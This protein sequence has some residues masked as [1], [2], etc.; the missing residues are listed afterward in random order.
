MAIR[1]PRWRRIVADTF[2][3]PLGV[4]YAS[5]LLAAIFAPEPV[6]ADFAT[7]GGGLL[8]MRP[9]AFY[10][11]SSDLVMLESDLPALIRRYPELRLPVTI[12][13]GERDR[14]LDPARHGTAV[15]GKVPGLSVETLP[16]AGHMLPLTR[17]DETAAFIRRVVARACE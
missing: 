13:F 3:A 2:A 4:R 15:R 1:S 10:A 11:N 12:L 7:R 17:P 5:R 16:G 8:A 14:I 9:Q 6:P